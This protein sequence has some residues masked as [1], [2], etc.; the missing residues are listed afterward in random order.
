MIKIVGAE[1]SQVSLLWSTVFARTDI[2]GAPV[3][4]GV[5][6]HFF[7]RGINVAKRSAPAIKTGIDLS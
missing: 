1:D 7:K 5:C 4:A 6:A 2:T 3:H